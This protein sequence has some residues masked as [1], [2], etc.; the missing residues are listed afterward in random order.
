MYSLVRLPIPSC[1]DLRLLQPSSA[2]RHDFH[3]N[4]RLYELGGLT[5]NFNSCPELLVYCCLSMY[6]HSPMPAC[7]LKM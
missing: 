2:F 4:A 7:A 3:E 5:A 6:P 1:Q